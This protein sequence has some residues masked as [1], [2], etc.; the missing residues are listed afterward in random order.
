MKIGIVTTWSPSGAGMVSRAYF[1]ALSKDNEVFIFARGC[2]RQYDNIWDTSNV[3]WAKKHPSVTG[4]YPSEF[5]K[6]IKKNKI[7]LVLF[8]EQRRWDTIILAKKLNVITG[9]YVDYYTADTIP[10]FDLYDFLI[11]NTK[12]HYNVFKDHK[13][14]LYCQWGTDN[15]LF[16]PIKSIKNRPLTFI[17]SS[18]NNGKNAKIASW[19]DRTGA[20]F[21]LENFYKVKGNCRLVFLSQTKLSD[22]PIRWKEIIENDSRIMFI[23]KKFDY[24]PYHLGDI[25]LYPSRLDGIGLTL[26]EAISCG[27]PAIVTN[28]EPMSDFVIDNFNGFLIDV[29]QYQGRPD[30][31]FWPET[32]CDG[33]SLVEKIEKY[34]NDPSLVER[35]SKNSRKLALEKFDWKK[36]SQGLA[37]WISN[38]K[39]INESNS[40]SINGVSI[41]IVRR[42]DRTHNPTPLQRILVGIKRLII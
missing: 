22:C 10:F 23:D 4:I 5:K 19:A 2:E 11:C 38:I 39:K 1:N 37:S 42:Y 16:S 8:N 14:V 30:G 25:Y 33:D 15:E 3:T 17:V 34:I 7:N 35:H 41:K 26:P 31:Y 18:G 32:I 12:R 36:N 40:H 21:I 13:N 24:T 27:L 28:S 9:A 29:Y 6:W 20:G